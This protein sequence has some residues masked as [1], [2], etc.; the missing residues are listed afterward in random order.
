CLPHRRRPKP[1]SS[2]HT[3]S[4]ALLASPRRIS[5]AAHHRTLSF[6]T[7]ILPCRHRHR[8]SQRA[9]YSGTNA[10]C[11]SWWRS[12]E[13]SRT[14]RLRVLDK[15]RGDAFVA[16]GCLVRCSRCSGL[17]G[18][19]V[20]HPLSLSLPPPPSSARRVACRIDPRRRLWW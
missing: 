1:R 4:S 13:G 7:A 3:A 2:P 10:R 8:R 16:F 12:G 14:A 17:A 6:S 11:R 20:V 9:G 18:V 15:G 5:R 19:T